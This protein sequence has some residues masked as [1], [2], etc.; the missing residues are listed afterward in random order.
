MTLAAIKM[1]ESP[2]NG[3]VSTLEPRTDSFSDYQCVP[4]LILVLCSIVLFTHT[5][6][7][8]EALC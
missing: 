5:P 6:K 1:S 8:M 3:A 2:E 4:L 7:H